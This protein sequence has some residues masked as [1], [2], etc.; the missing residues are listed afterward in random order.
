MAE[1]ENAETLQTKDDPPSSLQ[2]DH[3]TLKA[4]VA[5]PTRP[6]SPPSVQEVVVNG[7]HHGDEGSEEGADVEEDEP[8]LSAVIDS[9][10]SSCAEPAVPT[11]EV[12]EEESKS[13]KPWL[14]L[15]MFGVVKLNQSESKP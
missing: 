8:L 3:V 1:T 12:S 15:Q 4:D 6:A 7:D 11:S 13:R 9:G 5:V 10:D 2:L 14:P